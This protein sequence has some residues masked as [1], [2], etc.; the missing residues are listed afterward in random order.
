MPKAINFKAN[1]VVYFRGDVS[2]K[3]YILKSGRV[4][5]RSNDIE[6]G[7]EINEQIKT[8]EFFGVKS[9]LGKYPREETAMV[10]SDSTMLVFSVP[11]F[12]QVVLKNTRI[13][14]KMLKV[15]S[16][17]LRR[18]HKQVQNLISTSDSETNP[19]DGLF[20]IGE[21]YLKNKRYRQALYTFQRYLLYYPHGKYAEE[22]TGNISLA[23][24]Y[25]QRN[26]PL[27]DENPNEVRP[28]ARGA[29]LSAGARE[30]Y[31]AVSLFS[32]QRYDEALKQFKLI[33]EKGDDDEY[34]A[35]SYYEIGRCLFASNK[36]TDTISH[37]T[38]LIQRYPKH[39]DLADALFYVASAYGKEGSAEKAKGLFTK[40][41]NMT[42]EDNPVNRKT[43]KAL[44]SLEGR[45]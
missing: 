10:L 33:V 12:E 3:I 44:K 43:R 9:S 16:N 28:A 39:P 21:Y 36:F 8:G 22:A 45:G 4:N 11:E 17:Q 34:V 38:G 1:S 35:K 23:E 7:Q 41:L 6:T 18:I 31:D 14:M 37:F 25:S 42:S 13:I 29:G 27:R 40:I 19:E 15:F 24:Q 2:E 26:V 30:Y 32:Q 5:L 20:Q